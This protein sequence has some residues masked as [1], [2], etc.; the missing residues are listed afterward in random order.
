MV[1]LRFQPAARTIDCKPTAATAAII[2]KVCT[3]II[4]L[5]ADVNQTRF[6]LSDPPLGSPKLT[7]RNRLP[8]CQIPMSYACFCATR[9]FS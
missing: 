6:I 1:T 4:C 9:I 8:I 2:V 3:F 7:S 5:L